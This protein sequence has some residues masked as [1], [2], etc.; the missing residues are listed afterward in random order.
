[1]ALSLRLLVLCVALQS[2]AGAALAGHVAGHAM[3][4]D[5]T[6]AA[7]EAGPH[8]A[9]AHKHHGIDPH[10][11]HAH[12][13]GS[14]GDEDE[15]VSPA[16]SGIAETCTTMLCCFGEPTLAETRPQFRLAARLTQ[17][18]DEPT[19]PAPATVYPQ[20]RPPRPA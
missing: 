18:A 6:A 11:A 13:T 12:A 16:A 3:A 2:F 5:A 20:K 15:T 8:A 9:H 1:V 10:A 14:A 7:A 19:S 4:V 17:R